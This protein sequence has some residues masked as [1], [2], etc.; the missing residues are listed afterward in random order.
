M[1]VIPSHGAL[2]RVRVITASPVRLTAPTPSQGSSRHRRSSSPWPKVLPPS[3]RSRRRRPQGAR[4]FVSKLRQVSPSPASCSRSPAR[5]PSRRASPA[6]SSS[7]KLPD[8]DACRQGLTRSATSTT[9]PFSSMKT[10]SIGNRMNAVWIDPPGANSSPVAGGRLRRPI[11]PKKRRANVTASRQE[12]AAPLPDRSVVMSESLGTERVVERH[13]CGA[14]ND[15]E[16]RG[17]DQEDEREDDL[18]GRLV[19]TLLGGV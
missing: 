12:I 14:E 6:A 13:E 4:R 19:R 10:A 1:T 2:S 3:G 18:H 11:K 5:K 7:T 9:T 16:Q 17:E 15:H 8:P